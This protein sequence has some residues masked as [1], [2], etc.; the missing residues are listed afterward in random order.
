MVMRPRCVAHPAGKTF[1]FV[2]YMRAEDAIN[3]KALLDG[4]SAPAVTGEHCI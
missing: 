1:A 2:N 4:R 3:A